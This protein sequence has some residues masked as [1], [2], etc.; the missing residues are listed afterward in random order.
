MPNRYFVL[1]KL[2]SDAGV[3]VATSEDVPG[4]A[5]ESETLVALETKLQ[6]LV[7]ELLQANGCLTAGKDVQIELVFQ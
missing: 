3:W 1:A 2:D 7:P 6:Y 4:L 5:T